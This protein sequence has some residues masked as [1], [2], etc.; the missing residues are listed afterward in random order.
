MK[1]KI[2]IVSL[3]IGLTLQFS[4]CKKSDDTISGPPPT[5][6]NL[7]MNSSFE[8]NDSASWQGWSR[9][10]DDT[11]LINLLTD[12]PTGG[13]RFSVKI[14]TV[15][16]PK[17]FISQVIA[18]PAGTH[19]Y[20]LSSWAKV[21]DAGG[22]YSLAFKHLDTLTVRKSVT[23][24]DP[25]WALY[26]VLD[27]LTSVAGDSIVVTLFGG[28]SQLSAGQTFYDVCKLEKLD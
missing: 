17:L 21:V 19:F 10:I 7:L 11:A 20:K 4:S 26:S 13:G 5:Y 3:L 24:T 6:P 9:T 27:T 8:S 12:T 14:E 22:N 18:V 1:Q 2:V 28:F 25:A 16:G 15:W 23:I